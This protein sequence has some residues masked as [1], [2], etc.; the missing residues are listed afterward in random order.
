MATST[1]IERE[2]RAFKEAPNEESARRILRMINESPDEAERAVRNLVPVE[3]IPVIPRPTPRPATTAATA[4][5]TWT[6]VIG[7]QTATPEELF[8]PTSLEDLVNIVTQAGTTTCVR[9]VGTGH[10]FSDVML[11]NDYLVDVTQLSAVL[12]VDTSILKSRPAGAP[13]LFSAEAG[14]SVASFNTALDAAGLALVNMGDYAGQTL[15]G[16]ISTGTH[17]TGIGLAGMANAVVSLV[18]VTSGAAVMQIEPTAGITDPTLFAAAHPT[19]TLKQDDA[20]FQS[21]VVSM[22]S[23]GLIYSV[24]LA[25]M[26]A[27][28]LTE[29]RVWDTWENLSADP[30]ALFATINAYRHYE[31]DINPYAVDG[32]HKCIVTMRNI[33]SATQRSGTRGIGNFFA[34]ILAQI[35]LAQ[36]ILVA[37]LNLVPALAPWAV[38][39][40]LGTL[41]DTDYVNKSYLVLDLGASNDAKAYGNEIAFPISSTNTSGFITAVN[42]ILAQ[43]ATLLAAGTAQTGPVACRFVAQGNAYMTPEFA[44][45][46][47]RVELDMLYGTKNGFTTLDAYQQTSYGSGGVPHWGLELDYL[48]GEGGT[49]QEMYPG[50]DSWISVYEA[51]NP[52]GTFTGPFTVRMDLP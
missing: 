23:M 50:Y 20:T 37:L 21:V 35:P 24:T 5:L 33:V 22:G 11:T 31:I 25:V 16:A 52:T 38:D 49:L 34:G 2:L 36:E 28:Y 45:S 1:E 42:A 14:I 6:N 43:A 30:A 51:M 44:G 47:C 9:A 8:Y 29:T 27:Y 4:T 40:A 32:A 19:W 7:N 18:I 48:T 26:P 15:V 41:V 12:P 13:P 10:S 46:T 39:Q 3:E 17:G